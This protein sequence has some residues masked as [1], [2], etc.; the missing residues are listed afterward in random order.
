MTHSFL[1]STRRILPHARRFFAPARRL[2]TLSLIAL[3]LLVAWSPTILVYAQPP[4]TS[5]TR[6]WDYP[7][8]YDYLDCVRAVPEGG[9]IATGFAFIAFPEVVQ[10]WTARLDDDGNEVWLHLEGGNDTDAG[11]YIDLT[12]DGG[13]IQ[14]GDIYS[15][16]PGNGF[17]AMI[18]KLDADGNQEWARALDG[19]NT[20]DLFYC[21]RTV[22][23]GGY[24]ACGEVGD[25]TVI[26]FAETGQILWEWMVPDPDDSFAPK[27]VAP[28]ADGGFIVAHHHY[29]QD[30]GFR[31]LAIFKLD[32]NG[33]L[34]WMNDEPEEGNPLYGWATCA[35]EDEM[36]N[37]FVCGYVRHPDPPYTFYISK[38]D[39]TGE[40]IWALFL[41]NPEP[42]LNEDN[43]AYDICFLADGNI[44]VGGQTRGVVNDDYLWL[45][46][47]TPDG[48]IL[49]STEIIGGEITSIDQGRDG[50][51]VAAWTPREWTGDHSE[52]IALTAWEPEVN[53]LLNPHVDIVPA[54][55]MRLHYQAYVNNILVDPSP[56]DVWATVTTPAGNTFPLQQITVTL[57]PGETFYRPRVPLD[58][59]AAAP[60]GEYTFELHVGVAP[61]AIPP[62]GP[63]G[64]RHMGLGA[65]TF[66]K[67]GTR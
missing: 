58:I 4:D 63:N 34:L 17:D 66:T 14:A 2:L 32:S 50:S 16:E 40:V 10:V 53:V 6:I 39:S 30:M 45:I 36:G 25:P 64:S 29:R 54:Q 62:G 46:K 26:R 12:P 43:K 13:F 49:W 22:P 21:V 20:V 41:V 61:P 65:F 23:A 57:Q 1:A 37:I 67:S 51:I 38:R 5:W 33:N 15:E 55:G 11:H 52:A 31:S 19:G 56:F 48:E 42:G 44:A 18:R 28:L 35:R 7:D 8:D 59:P 3:P 24:V 9:Y 47:A 27:W 60:P